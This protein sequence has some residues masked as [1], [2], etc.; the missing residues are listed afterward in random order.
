MLVL[1]LLCCSCFVGGGIPGQVGLG[2]TGCVSIYDAVFEKRHAVAFPYSA[3]KPVRLEHRPTIP[4]LFRDEDQLDG[5][6]AEGNVGKLGITVTEVVV[7]SLDKAALMAVKA[8]LQG[9]RGATSVTV[10]RKRVGLP[11]VADC[12]LILKLG[13]RHV[14]A[15]LTER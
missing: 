5:D 2:I 9:E 6:A 11:A 3:S 15:F 4:V 10:R 14:V 12:Q 1:P 7:A 13:C 8:V